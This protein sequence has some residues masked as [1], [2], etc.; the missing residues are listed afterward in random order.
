MK[1]TK[2]AYGF[3]VVFERKRKVKDYPRLSINDP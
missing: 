1:S 3:D 2:F